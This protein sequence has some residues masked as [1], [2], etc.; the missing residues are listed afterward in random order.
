MDDV[1]KSKLIDRY[2]E[3][4]FLYETYILEISRLRTKY[5][6]KADDSN[7]LLQLDHIAEQLDLVTE[8][9]DNLLNT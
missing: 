1:T 3:K 2:Q 4:I 8:K 6:W 9:I 5:H 7:D